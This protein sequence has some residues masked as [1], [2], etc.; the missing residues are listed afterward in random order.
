MRHFT[1]IELAGDY[2]F[3]G[4]ERQAAYSAFIRDRNLKPGID[5]KE[6]FAIYDSAIALPIKRYLSNEKVEGMTHILV[7][8]YSDIPKNIKLLEEYETHIRWITDFGMTGSTPKIYISSLEP[9]ALGE[10]SQ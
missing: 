10:T 7:E 8:S 1:D 6:F 9:I 2:K 5:A 4:I 3:R